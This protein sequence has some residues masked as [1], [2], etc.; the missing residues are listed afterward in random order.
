MNIDI[1]IFN[2]F[3][4]NI[5]NAL[6]LCKHSGIVH[7]FYTVNNFIFFRRGISKLLYYRTERKTVKYEADARTT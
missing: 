7:Y 3:F 4:V 1:L 2:Y 6:L 5:D